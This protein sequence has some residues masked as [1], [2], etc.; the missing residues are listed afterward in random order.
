[1]KNLLDANKE[2]FFSEIEEVC[3]RYG[4][5]ISHEDDQGGFIIELF[6]E[7]NINW[8][9]DASMEPKA[10][11]HLSTLNSEYWEK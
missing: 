3:K 2:M 4:L 11:A 1:M 6:D 5:S 7:F 10:K 9:K 8:L